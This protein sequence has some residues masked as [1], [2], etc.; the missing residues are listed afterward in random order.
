MKNQPQTQVSWPINQPLVSDQPPTSGTFLSLGMWSCWRK[1]VLCRNGRICSSW[2]HFAGW[3]TL[4]DTLLWFCRGETRRLWNTKL[5]MAGLQERTVHNIDC[6]YRHKFLVLE[7]TEWWPG[8]SF[9]VTPW[10]S[11]MHCQFLD[12][13]ASLVESNWWCFFSRWNSVSLFDIL[14]LI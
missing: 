5:T 12:A 11:L 13:E 1:E 7:R 4:L 3:G 9:I 6:I 10:F 2:L 8:A 14:E